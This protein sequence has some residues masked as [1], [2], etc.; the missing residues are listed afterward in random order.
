MERPADAESASASGRESFGLPAP[1]RA[2]LPAQ[3]RQDATATDGGQVFQAGGNVNV[4]LSPNGRY[5]R[6]GPPTGDAPCPYPG[7][8]SFGL[9]QAAW[10]FG[11]ETLVRELVDRLAEGGPLAVVAPSG[12]GKSSLLTAGLRPALLE[13]RLPVAGSRDWPHLVLTPT[14]EP[15][16]ALARGLATI[17]GRPAE[18]ERRALAENPAGCVEDLRERVGGRFPGAGSWRI[19][20]IVDQLEELF[21]LCTD[22]AARHR[23]VEALGLL[24]TSGPAG[25]QPVALL[26]YGLRAD[27]YGECGNFP[28]LQAALQDHQIF[29]GPMTE[30]ELRS[31]ITAPAEAVGLVLEEGLEELLLRDLGMFPQDSTVVGSDPAAWFTAGR[32]PLLAHALQMTWSARDGNLLTVAEY[33]ASGG[34]HRAI[35]TSAERSWTGLPPAARQ[36]AE[37]LFLRLVR[38]G[39]GAEDTRRRVLL[40]DLDLAGPS[41]TAVALAVFT[42]DR[43]LTTSKERATELET[44]QITHEAMIKAWPRL[45]Q[46]IDRSRAAVLV[47]QEVEEAAQAWRAE[48]AD[49][50]LLY[51]GNR[52]E[53]ARNAAGAA[54]DHVSSAAHA[55]IGASVRRAT[56]S[57]QVRRT[58]TAALV[59]LVLIAS[60]AATF[61]FQQRETAQT[62]RDTAQRERDNAVAGQIAI[63]ADRIRPSDPSL[64]ARFDLITHRMRPSDSTYANLIATENSPLSTVVPGATSGAVFSADGARMATIGQENAV[65][66][67]DVRDPGHPRRAG[68]PLPEKASLH[69]RLALSADGRRL[70]V[71]IADPDPGVPAT[72]SAV[73][74]DVSDP[75]QPKPIGGPVKGAQRVWLTPDGRTVVTAGDETA[76]LWGISDSGQLVPLATVAGSALALSPDGRTLVLDRD[77]MRL[78]DIS[79]PGHPEPLPTDALEFGGPEGPVAVFSR[80]GR[81]LATTGSQGGNG[82]VAT[83]YQTRLLVWD[84][85]DRA[86]PVQRNELVFPNGEVSSMAFGADGTV[87]ATAGRDRQIRLWTFTGL[88]NVVTA[89]AALVASVELGPPLT[90]YT[91]AVGD[92]AFSPDGL[93]LAAGDG[94]TLRLWSL[95]R[96]TFVGSG[97]VSRLRFGKDNRTLVAAGPDSSVRLTDISDP[98]RPTGVGGPLPGQG[99]KF[100]PSMALTPDRRTLATVGP[101]PVLSLWDITDGPRPKLLSSWPVT[102]EDPKSLV[103]DLEFGADGKTLRIDTRDGVRFWDATD[104]ARASE[105]GPETPAGRSFVSLKGTL[106]P[107]GRLMAES[108]D[109]PGD[110]MQLWEVTDPL[111]AGKPGGAAPVGVVGPYKSAAFSPRGD[112]LVAFSD[113]TA[114]LWD[115]TDPHR[116]TA[117]GTPFTEPADALSGAE[118]VL[119]GRMLA[120]ASANT[121]RIWNVADPS[122]VRSR[123]LVTLPEPV[124]AFA[125]TPDGRLLATGDGGRV[126]LWDLDV[127][128]AARRVCATT[129]GV[130]TPE[131]WQA[132]FPDLP[133]RSPC[134]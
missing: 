77:S 117:L 53:A 116:P 5:Q 31:A 57:A 7:L 48:N 34:I 125:T 96:T 1:G 24:S 15:M 70:A 49:S 126:R 124:T 90:G 60:G 13:G 111:T 41:P 67:W 44:V 30:A 10:Y 47:R 25:Q 43:L 78:V 61:A 68:V 130:L 46:W 133:F 63:E 82:E 88:R 104:P 19:V 132:H 35:A 80:D 76:A 113:R 120:S 94:S 91:G 37:S 26:V 119:D 84:L 56:R 95:P 109:K 2:P 121:V 36:A 87:L 62:Q 40:T 8:A 38:I 92:V 71:V 89:H 128:H 101:G 28:V 118:F 131:V 74:W 45:R 108:G 6:P 4:F 107:D 98:S 83:G 112:R 9:E 73:V 106:S 100:G 54:P 42:R 29:V 66:L 3:L 23:F 27:F 115:I 64:A 72:Y 134:P 85:T 14:A 58:V 93:T 65:L 12:A 122:H 18:A 39:T 16:D 32:L 79:R 69:G 114:Q 33:R 75:A 11:R 51:R 59:A 81:L 110:P 52:L 50:A 129:D 21:T 127:E 55:F 97:Y 17:S 20:L 103:G 102:S 123:P 99:G 22:P 86:H 105:V